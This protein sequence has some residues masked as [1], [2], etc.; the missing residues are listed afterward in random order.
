MSFSKR[1]DTAQKFPES[2][3]CLIGI[4][5]Y[6]ELD[7]DVYPVF[8]VD[9]DEGGCSLRPVTYPTKVQIGER[10]VREGEVPL[11]DSTRGRVLSLAGVNEQG[12]QN[13]DVEDAGNQNDDVQDARNNVTKE[14]AADGQ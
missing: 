2:F 5:R 4:S 9:D 10:E 12:N 11:L 13:D 3:L 1:F 14:G 8:L 7:D 6:Y